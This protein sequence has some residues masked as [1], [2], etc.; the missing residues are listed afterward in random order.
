VTRHAADPGL[1]RQ[2]ASSGIVQVLV[3]MDEASG[4]RE[5]A[6]VGVLAAGD[7][8]G[9]ETVVANG[10]AGLIGRVYRQV[11]EMSRSELSSW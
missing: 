3:D 4:Q 11:D 6:G 10:R 2:L 7:Q 9:V 8:Q 5:P 1:L